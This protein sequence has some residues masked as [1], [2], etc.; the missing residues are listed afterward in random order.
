MDKQSAIM[1]FD[2]YARTDDYVDL[3]F[4]QIDVVVTR[5][6]K[7]PSATITH[8]AYIAQQEYPEMFKPNSQQRTQQQEQRPTQSQDEMKQVLQDFLASDWAQLTAG[9]F[10]PLKSDSPVNFKNFCELLNA[11]TVI[12]TGT[13]LVRREV[14]ADIATRLFAQGLLERPRIVERV[15]EVEKTVP[16]TRKQEAKHNFN[17]DKLM[18]AP[19]VDAIKGASEA[20]RKESHRSPGP[21]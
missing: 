6:M 16:L 20:G 1:L 15:V 19:G 9:A 10:L 17:L 7:L 13:K 5:L 3:S 2:S 8:V 4:R 18:N 11:E 14:L 21:A 12:G